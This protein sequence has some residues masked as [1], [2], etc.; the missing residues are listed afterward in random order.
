MTQHQ[1]PGHVDPI[2]AAGDEP[3]SNVS[4]NAYF[5]DILEAR[6]SRRTLLRGSLAA[7]IAGAMATGLPFGR[8]LA[9]GSSSPSIGFQAI[10]IGTGDSVVVPEGYRVQAFIPWGTPISG[11]MPAFSLDASGEDQAHQIGSHHD[12]MH[13]FA[14][15]GSSRDGLLVLNHEYV[16]PRFLHGAAAGLALDADG[17]PQHEDGSRD[18]DQVRKELNAH[19]VS[20]VRVRQG[21]DGQWQVVEDRL[22][23]R[24]TGLTPMQLAGPVAGTEHVVTKYSPDGSMTRGTLNNCAHGVTPWNTYLAAEENWAGYFANEDVEIDR[25]QSRYGIET[26]AEGRYQWH[27]AQGGAD[28]FVRFDATSH[29]TSPSEDY[30]NEP[31]AFGYMVEIDPF[32]PQST[33]VKR[34]HLGRFAHEGV[35]FAPAVEGQPVVAYS[36]DDARFEY[37]YKF[38][39]AR[40]YQAASADGS[41]LDEGTLY[42]ARFN[43]DGSGEWLALAPGQ[44]GL[45]PENGFA[46]LADI[47]VNTRSAADHVGA[48]KMDRPEWGAVDPAT[49]QV[50]F[51][52]TNNTRRSE[53]QVDAANPRA[54]NHFGH[55]I[56]W[57]EEGTHAA[58]RFTWDIFVLAGDQDSGR[59]LAG[60]PLGQEAIFASPDGLWIDPD[61]RVWIQTDISESVMNTGIHEVFGNNQMLV[62]DPETGEIRRFLTGPIGQEITGVVTTPD[63]RTMF[64]NVQH[65]GATTSAEAFAAGESVSHWPDGGSAIPRSATLVITR[66][67]G[68]IIGA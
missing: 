63:Q 55:I 47:L 66:E 2:L 27:R 29:G 35:I 60:E 18:A 19:G 34:T 30:R 25:R 61:R 13:F 36:G 3:A 53:E 37:I 23:R 40:P 7:A 49:G 46:D 67:D 54:E 31:H 57:Q 4:G 52:L 32:D 41:L 65:P 33:P 58:E 24:V 39:S 9:A 45:T 38:V 42:V 62:A 16:E 17:F 51:T 15:D 68:G 14:I 50:Y 21:D 64:V 10:P 8:A 43:D 1:H 44:N 59:D 12:G 48:T 11:S 22:N 56:R 26:R 5:G 20:V 6:M 28:E